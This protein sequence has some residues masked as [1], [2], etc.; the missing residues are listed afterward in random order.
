MLGMPDHQFH[1]LIAHERVE[2]LR[3]TMLASRR[4]P[5]RRDD[6]Q[7][8]KEAG[9]LTPRLEPQALEPRQAA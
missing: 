7:E 1:A 4:R 6:D 8:P 5:W 3:A 9:Q 2:S